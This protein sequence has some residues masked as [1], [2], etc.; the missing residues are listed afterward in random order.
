MMQYFECLEENVSCFWE[1]TLEGQV[2]RTRHGQKGTPGITIEKVFG[3]ADTAAQEYD[4]LTE[5]KKK[6]ES[7]YFRLGDAYTL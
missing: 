5:E 3:D 6:D 2:V 7:Y 4:R 1:I